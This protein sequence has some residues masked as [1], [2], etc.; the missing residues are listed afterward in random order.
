MAEK[1][2]A[3]LTTII[4]EFITA[5]NK[6]AYAQGREIADL[7]ADIQS[8]MS[9]EIDT[10]IG[11]IEELDPKFIEFYNQVKPIIDAQPGT[12]EFD[13]GQNLYTL[14]EAASNAAAAAQAAADAAAATAGAAQQTAQANATALAN[15][16]NQRI[17]AIADLVN[18]INAL[19]ARVTTVEGKVTAHNELLQLFDAT[20]VNIHQNFAAGLRGKVSPDGHSFTAYDTSGL[21]NAA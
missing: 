20:G 8:S 13:L 2:Q 15:E 6:Q 11:A 4:G 12:P 10:K 17:A 14:S 1:T 7:L 19:D 9:N 5:Y 3:E 21:A 18:T 16:S